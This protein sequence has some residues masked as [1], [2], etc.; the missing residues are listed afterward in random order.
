MNN[1]EYLVDGD[2]GVIFFKNLLII[3]AGQGHPK[4]TDLAEAH[5]V[6]PSFSGDPEICDPT[7]GVA[8]PVDNELSFP[9]PQ[10][11]PNLE[12]L[13]HGSGILTLYKKFRHSM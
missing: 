7:A 11:T 10:H 9:E 8:F 6:S 4:G 13:D 12:A 3:I 2:A 1:S 5:S